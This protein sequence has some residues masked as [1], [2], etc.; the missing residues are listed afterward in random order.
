MPMNAYEARTVKFSEA[1]SGFDQDEVNAFRDAVAD[2]LQRWEREV[3]EAKRQVE[4][5]ED[6]LSGI[7]DAEEAVR[8]TFL[9]A[10]TTKREMLAETREQ[11]DRER[12]EATSEAT[13]LRDEA[14]H[15]AAEMRRSAEA[16]AAEVLTAARAAAA[17]AEEQTRVEVERM[18]QRLTQM[19]TAVRDLHERIQAFATSALDELGVTESLID[20][21]TT[22]L[23]EIEAFQV[24]EV[25]GL[26]E[27]QT[28]PEEVVVEEPAAEQ[29]AQ[30]VA[31]DEVAVD[32]VAATARESE[33]VAEVEPEPAA[34]TEPEVEIEIEIES[35]PE[36]VAGTIAEEPE[37]EPVP[38]VTA[39]EPPKTV[40][41]GADDDGFYQRRLAGLRRRMEGGDGDA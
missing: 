12:A 41:R 40:L 39:P 18:E 13:R 9:A 33:P 21:E 35:V 14:E 28:V 27:E 36:P 22:T 7:S 37:P 4:S 10:A 8:Q 20:L 5:A 29:T 16:D 6:R 19:R 38:A 34:E 30:E 24:P 25:E 26:A 3:E 32:E 1:R 23:E 2:S 31:V 11:T 15:E 17:E